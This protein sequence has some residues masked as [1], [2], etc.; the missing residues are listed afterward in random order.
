MFM[1]LTAWEIGTTKMK[2]RTKTSNLIVDDQLESYTSMYD[3]RIRENPQFGLS[4]L[5]SLVYI[6]L[7]A[8]LRILEPPRVNLSNPEAYSEPCQISKMEIFWR[9]QSMA[10]RH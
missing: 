4:N 1:T 9:K 5:I 7:S 2:D 10:K 8:Y 3:F 6:N